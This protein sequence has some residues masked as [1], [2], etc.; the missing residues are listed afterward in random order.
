M[1]IF[2]EEF[3]HLYAKNT[4]GL[5]FELI[6]FFFLLFGTDF[7]IECEDAHSE[8][9]TPIWDMITMF[10]IIVLVK[11]PHLNHKIMRVFSFTL[12]AFWLVSYFKFSTVCSY[13]VTYAFQSE[14]TLY[15]CLNVIA[16]NR[17]KIW[18]LS[19]CNSHLNFRFR[20]CFEYGVPWHSGNYRV[21]IHSE[22]RTWHNKNI[23]P[24]APYR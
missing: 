11:E 6:E 17:R 24:N 8:A 10:F 12:M 1:F 9:I 23:Q 20:T 15:N 7:W 21:R 19:D 3:V 16:R 14:S 5:I 13:H 4:V 22:M 18:S 2:Y